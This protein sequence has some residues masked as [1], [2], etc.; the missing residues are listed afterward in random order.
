MN[1]GQAGATFEG[2]VADAGHAVRD[3]DGGQ[4]ATARESSIADAGHAV[5]LALICNG[6]RYDYITRIRIITAVLISHGCLAAGEIVEDT[7][8][9]GIV[10]IG[11]Q[12]QQGHKKE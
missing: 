10:G 12:W 1:G 2:R 11:Q 6:C 4:A 5:G 7:V 8:N 3:G 9:V